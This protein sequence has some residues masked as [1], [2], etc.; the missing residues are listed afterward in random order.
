MAAGA[1]LAAMRGRIALLAVA[2]GCGLC[3]AARAGGTRSAGDGRGAGA[4]AG[5]GED[6]PARGP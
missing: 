5:M 2:I 1:A 3:R 6:R 4:A